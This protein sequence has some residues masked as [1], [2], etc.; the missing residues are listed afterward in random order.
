MR[1][2]LREVNV[3]AWPECVRCSGARPPTAR[4]SRVR[5]LVLV[6]AAFGAGIAGRE[7]GREGG[8]G[9]ELLLKPRALRAGPAGVGQRET[10]LIVVD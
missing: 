1:R 3:K 5:V 8:K 10:Y 4:S 9:R 6:C 2:E 7:G